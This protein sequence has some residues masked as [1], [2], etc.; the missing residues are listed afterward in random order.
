ML[1]EVGVKRMLKNRCYANFSKLLKEYLR[2]S[3]LLV[4]FQA[5]CLE[6][7]YKNPPSQVSFKYCL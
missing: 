2:K 5:V 7:Y 3:S 4:K 1:V 6:I